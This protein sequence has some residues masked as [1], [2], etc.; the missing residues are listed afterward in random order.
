MEKMMK[1][2][3]NSF[4]N[5][6]LSLL[7][8][9]L[10]ITS[11][12]QGGELAND[13]LSGGKIEDGSITEEKL[14]DGSVTPA[15]LDRTYQELLSPGTTAQYFRGDQTWQTLNTSIVPE[16][17]NLYYTDA[18]SRAAISATSPL[19]YS[20]ATGVLSL[21]TVPVAN[22]GTGLTS[23][24]SAD[25]LLGINSGATGAEYKS[26]LG[27]T[28]QINVTH[29]AGSITLNTPQDIAPASSPTFAGLTVTGL[30]GFV[31]ATSGSLSASALS[32][33]DVT[34]ALGYTP[35]NLAGDTMTGTLNLPSNGLQV[36]T[37]DLTFITGNVGMGTTSPS[38]KLD[39]EAEDLSTNAVTVAARLTHSTTGIPTAGQG[40]GFDLA[41]ETSD[42]LTIS[43]LARIQGIFTDA[44]TGAED[45]D[46]E[47][48]IVANGTLNKVMSL[49]SSGNVGIG[50]SVTPHSVLQVNG[51]LAT[52]IST[53][54]ALS[55]TITSTDSII[56][57]DATSNSVDIFL[58]SASGIAGRQY[59]IKRVDGSANVATVK[60]SIDGGI[61]YALLQWQYI[62]VVSD[63][64][65]WL[66]IANN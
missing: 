46:L 4:L 65:K 53:Q 17:G 2:F 23:L 3:K 21:G 60:G 38:H 5:P 51:A 11:C 29:A 49:A 50:T 36:G 14:A 26:L 52:A 15:K 8:L 28:N 27:T 30:S 33:T 19:S 7:M 47:F 35:V 10:T 59:T 64:I 57:A 22:G 13:S 34:T 24:G 18:R 63:G 55:Y 43:T 31:R 25:Q 45:A 39:L 61:D 58:P 1:L 37:N 66:M 56:I 48:M 54:T 62:T 20:S 16:F 40:T 41:A 32:S 12:R 42:E 9:T 6:H 44:T